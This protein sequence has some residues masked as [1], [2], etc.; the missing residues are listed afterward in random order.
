[1]AGG[2]KKGKGG[3]KVRVTPKAT[4]QAIGAGRNAKGAYKARRSRA[5]QLGI[6]GVP[7]YGR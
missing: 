6:T 4:R 3:A 2:W 1:M 7:A 5:A